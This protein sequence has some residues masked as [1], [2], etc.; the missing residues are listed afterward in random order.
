MATISVPLGPVEG[1]TWTY[2]DEMEIED[3]TIKSR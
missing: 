1:D 2:V 3:Q